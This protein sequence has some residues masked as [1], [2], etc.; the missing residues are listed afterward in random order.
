MR[1]PAESLFLFLFFQN[2]TPPPLQP[3]T[4]QVYSKQLQGSES[5]S[6]KSAWSGFNYYYY[7]FTLLVQQMYHLRKALR[8]QVVVI[9]ICFGKSTPSSW[10]LLANY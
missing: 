8:I 10:G 6:S 9:P 1:C 2:A 4:L 3:H 5:L 7:Y